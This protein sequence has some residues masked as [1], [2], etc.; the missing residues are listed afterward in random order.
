MIA[1]L[2]SAL[3]GTGMAFIAGKVKGKGAEI[4]GFA[5]AVPFFTYAIGAPLWN[6]A[7]DVVGFNL[8]GFAG[9]EVFASLILAIAL[10]EVRAREALS[11]DEYIQV[12]P[13]SSFVLSAGA[14]LVGTLSR[15]WYLLSVIILLLLMFFPE[16]NPERWM[17]C[18]PFEGFGVP[19]ITDDES[20][21]AYVIANRVF[22]G[23]FT[24]QNFSSVE[25]LIACLLRAAEKTKRAARVLGYTCLLAPALIVP[26]LSWD[27]LS[28]LI[29]AL[30]VTFL[31]YYLWALSMVVLS[32]R[33]VPAECR[34]VLEEYAGFMRKTKRK[35]EIIVS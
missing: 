8:R 17:R 6:I 34:E 16:K 25:K 23:G 1:L 13:L 28:A 10:I 3:I 11:I 24:L 26:L 18:Q 21:S 33:R 19:C 31:C 32:R 4:V 27:F 35:R 9:F 22:V 14:G 5:T 30:A 15:M 20:R 7:G 12:A 29:L 2:L